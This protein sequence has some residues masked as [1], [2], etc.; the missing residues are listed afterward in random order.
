M[1]TPIF[2]E[3]QK[4]YTLINKKWLFLHFITS[5]S[6]VVINVI[7]EVVI[8]KILS[9]SNLIFTTINVYLMNYFIIPTLVN[10]LIVFAEYKIY[11]SQKISQEIKIYLISTL[12]V[13][14]CFMIFIVHGDYF[15]SL[16]I[17]FSAPIILTAIYGKRRITIFTSI[18]ALMCYVSS[19]L[20][21]TWGNDIIDV[22]DDLHSITKFVVAIFVTLSF[23]IIS[24]IIIYFE[25]ERNLVVEKKELESFNLKQKIL[26]D[27]LTKTYNRKAL[28]KA[29]NNMQ[30]DKTKNSYSFVM[31]DIDNF[32]LLNDTYGHVAGDNC[33]I[34]LTQIIKD[35]CKDSD[36]FRYGGDEF[37]IIFKNYNHDDITKICKSIQKNFEPI[38]E[39]YQTHSSVSLSF[40]I[41]DYKKNTPPSSLIVNSDLALYKSKEEKNKI[42]IFNKSLTEKN[43][44]EYFYQI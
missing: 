13:F 12:F 27:E 34:D 39:E 38:S 1:K 18:L 41:A 36:V 4:E 7:L 17:I 28:R 43:S 30:Y 11:F 24:L 29:L 2:Q 37:S 19:E 9:D 25:K 22:F 42:T 21:I 16:F 8:G 40:G 20:F 6:V 14:I 23:V 26:M 33:L 44:P 5:I 31:V 32:K 3:I 15:E 10:L 35:H